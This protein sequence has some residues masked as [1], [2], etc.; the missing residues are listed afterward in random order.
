VYNQQL[1]PLVSKK[2]SGAAINSGL[3]RMGI[4][5]EAI[6]E[7]GKKRTTINDKSHLYGFNLEKRNFNGRE[8]EAIVIDDKGK[9]FILD[10]IED[11]MKQQ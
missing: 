7:E 6:N 11:I 4:L 5:S 1:H 3:K 2:T 10:N 9:Q 8:Y